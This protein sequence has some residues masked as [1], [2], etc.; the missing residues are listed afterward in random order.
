MKKNRWVEDSDLVKVPN[1]NGVLLIVDDGMG[2][3]TI[4][5]GES[6]IFAIWEA[7]NSGSLIPHEVVKVLDQSTLVVRGLQARAHPDE[8]LDWDKDPRWSFRRSHWGTPMVLRESQH[9]VWT[10]ANEHRFTL[11][12]VPKCRTDSGVRLTENKEGVEIRF[13]DDEFGET[14]WNGRSRLYANL[15]IGDYVY[16][17]WVVRIE[18]PGNGSVPFA[19][20]LIVRRMNAEP[21]FER[22]HDWDGEQVWKISEVGTVQEKTLTRKADGN[23]VA[24]D[25]GHRFFKLSRRPKCIQS[26]ERY[27]NDLVLEDQISWG[28]EI[29]QETL[30][31]TGIVLSVR[32]AE[33]EEIVW[34][35][36]S[37]LWAVNRETENTWPFEVL[38]VVS[39]DE[40][41]VREVIAEQDLEAEVDWVNEQAWVLRPRVYSWPFIIRQIA[42]GHWVIPRHDSIKCERVQTESDGIY[43]TDEVFADPGK[44]ESWKKIL[45]LVTEPWIFDEDLCN[46]GHQNALEA[47]RV[48]DVLREARES[49]ERLRNRRAVLREKQGK[50]EPGS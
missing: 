2:N 15:H 12:L 39:E 33:G 46:R 28:D 35:G 43:R 30:N 45:H 21:D 50:S 40:V 13:T 1:P 31:S 41:L 9:D 16:P 17:F 10:Y 44:V 29:T 27:E 14:L 25:D 23:W 3:P 5:D 42:P 20:H 6:P 48:A 38:E 36:G 22:G 37:K 8:T 11:S 24:E 47:Q 18:G 34:S 19:P 4:W 7:K 49:K 26:R 32:N